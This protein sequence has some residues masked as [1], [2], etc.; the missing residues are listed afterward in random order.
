MSSKKPNVQLALLTI[1]A[2]ISVTGVETAVQQALTANS[3]MQR[4]PNDPMDGWQLARQ[5]GAAVAEQPG[6]ERLVGRLDSWVKVGNIVA[7]VCFPY[8]CSPRGLK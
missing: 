7:K 3:A 2:S 4:G 5:F 1:K 8:R 6:F